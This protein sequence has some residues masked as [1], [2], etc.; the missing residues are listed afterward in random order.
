[1]ADFDSLPAV[2][3][4]GG[5]RRRGVARLHEIERGL[6]RLL[7][8]EQRAAA[9][10]DLLVRV[11]ALP[12]GRWDARG[13]DGTAPDHLGLLIVEATGVPAAARERRHAHQEVPRGR[14]AL[15][16]RQQAA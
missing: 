3:L 10:R 2:A 8:E 12:G 1:M 16:L 13:L 7:P 4:A 6:G 11:A 5:P 15:L 9:T 14:R